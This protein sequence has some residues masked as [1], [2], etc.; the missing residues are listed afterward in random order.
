MFS[1]SFLRSK[2]PAHAKRHR[3]QRFRPVLE[4]LEDRALL[5]AGTLDPT[6]GAGGKVLTDF[7]A[8][9]VATAVAMQPTD[10]KIVVA[11]NT[12]SGGGETN[13]ALAR[14][15]PDGS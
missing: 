10:D 8:E 11:G 13:F 4:L 1:R 2:R 9:E 5:T 14:Y 12:T 7:G 15:N 3:Q 6:F